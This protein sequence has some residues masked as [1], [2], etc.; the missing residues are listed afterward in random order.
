MHDLSGSWHG[1]YSYPHA[2]D[3]VFFTALLMHADPY[4]SG[5]TEEAAD[6]GGAVSASLS[7]RL[8]GPSV[9]FLKMYDT[10]TIRHDCISYQGML[11]PDGTEIQGRWIIPGNWSGTFLMMREA[12]AR[13]MLVERWTARA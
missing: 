7:G 5:T 4:L 13:L 3:P 10:Q 6:G 12:A 2:L 1:L 8:S 9:T 11:D